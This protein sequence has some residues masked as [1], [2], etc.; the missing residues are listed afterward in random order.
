MTHFHTLSYILTCEIPTLLYTW[1]LKKAPLSG[2]ASPYSVLA[3]IGSTPPPRNATGYPYNKLT[4]ELNS[5]VSLDSLD[6]TW[7]ALIL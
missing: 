6:F 7:P 3:N 4:L 1:S 2:G 5:T